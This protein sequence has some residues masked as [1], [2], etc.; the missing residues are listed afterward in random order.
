MAKQKESEPVG[1]L[2]IRKAARYL[3]VS[4]ITMRR[5]IERGKIKPCR[6]LRHLLIPVAELERFLSEGQ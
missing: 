2:K 5:L 3:S 1:A 6:A 4:E